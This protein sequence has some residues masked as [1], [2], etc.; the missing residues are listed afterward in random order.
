MSA[1]SSDHGNF[2]TVNKNS[3]KLS[4][5]KI[6]YT[7]CDCLTQT[8]FSE[9]QNLVDTESPDIIALTEI[10]PKNYLFPPEAVHRQIHG[11][12][13]YMSEPD[14]G[15]GVCIYAKTILN[16]SVL[17]CITEFSDQIWCKV[18]LSNLDNLIIGCIYRSPNGSRQNLTS[19]I[20]LLKHIVDQKPS[21]LLIMGD[22]NFKEIDWAQGETTVG[23][24]H[25]ATLFLEAIRDT[26]L[27]QHVR[28]ATRYRSDNI[29][30][31]LDLILTN[32][33]DMVC[34]IDYQPGLGSSDHVAL[35]FVF[36][37][38][39]DVTYN[40]YRKLN[41][42]K[43]DYVSMNQA[44]AEV[45]W[46]VV[47][48][49]LSL[50][51]SWE[52][53]AEKIVEYIGIYVPVSKAVS[54]SSRNKTPMTRECIRVIK[55]KH[56]KWLKYKYCRTHANFQDYKIA[57]NRASGEVRK[58][59]YNYEK[60][61]ALR[62]KENNKLFWSY[63]RSKSKT[64]KSVCKLDK[65]NGELTKDEQETASI[66]NDYFASVFE[67][68]D[69]QNL[70][71]FEEQSYMNILENID[72][73]ENKVLKAINQVNPNKS[74]GPDSF[75][76][77]LIKETQKVLCKPL[78]IIYQKSLSEAKVPYIW[79]CANVT[80]IYK[81][82][83]KSKLSNY[84]PI[85]LTSV[86]GKIMERLIRDALVQHMN[87]NNLF[88][89]E[90]H[91]FIKGK[92]CVTQLLEFMEDITE[93]IDQGLEVDVI[94]LDFSKAFDKVPHKRLLRK[95]SGYGIKGNVLNWI[96]EFLSNRKQRVIINGIS[97]DWRNV[98]SGIPQGSVL[99][100]ILFLIFINDMPK[101]IQCLVKLFAD[102]A[103]LYQ[104]VKSDQDRVD[105]QDDIVSSKNWTD[106]WKM[107]FNIKKCKH[108]HLGSITTDSRY[109]MPSELGNVQIDKV[110][111]EKDLGVVIDSKLNFR[112]H[113]TSKV[114]IANRNLGIIFR[115]FTYLSQEMFM[116]L[117]KSMVRPHLEYA[118]VIWSP[119][120]KKDKIVIENTQ[121]RA[122]RLVPSLKGLSY[123]ER[124]RRLGL[125]TLE[126]RRERADVVEVY[127]ILNNIDLVNKEKLFQMATYQATRGH[128]LKLFKKRARLNMRA[129]SFS[130]RVID[131]WNNLPASV[132][133]APSLEAFKSRLNK[134][135]QYHP[136]KFTA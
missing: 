13:L 75:H 12:D 114:A 132:V 9:L 90:Q 47:F 88:C 52:C 115:T 77:K 85:S 62:I 21:H 94:Y 135:W 98:T 96:S 124:L 39:I 134:H 128:P 112:Q 56:R 29:P 113:I 25:I 2:N 67:L 17:K 41:F 125:P 37:C 51:E 54:D 99:G 46:N 93:A 117:Y 8:K 38:F 111:E 14:L 57:R 100:P 40:T 58:T 109:H 4:D 72:I 86:P 19:M 53:L 50:C 68:E 63:V 44:L 36:N 118:S 24:E 61:L 119:L 32:E 87:I 108:L 133:M 70:P 73:T 106:T 89:I 35:S 121:R 16:S 107:I 45:D 66:L 91:G 3:L 31:V 126:Y 110:E 97:S 130:V 28:E 49:D 79:K 33:E 81:S 127:K 55:D 20:D 74:Q 11:Y 120:Y 5:L 48:G 64:K 102:D 7:N 26:Y 116:N 131:N 34:Q 22:F 92:S 1:V 78:T 30:S 122:T 76:P 23:E 10:F 80:A 71:N 6:Y 82:G 123:P 15:R 84:R 95:I 105:L 42:F 101:A 43:A 59:K 69:D 129:N 18:K 83:D 60:D 103:K 104:I 65:G 136:A 27:F